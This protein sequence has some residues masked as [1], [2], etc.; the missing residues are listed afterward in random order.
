LEA[1]VFKNFFGKKKMQLIGL[2]I[3]TRYIKAV[4]L[5][6]DKDQIKVQAVACEAINGNAFAERDI[7][8]FEAVSQALRKIKLV[9][10]NK[11]KFVAIAIAGPSV[12][13]KVVYMEPDQSD[14]ELESQIELEAESLI[15]Y[16]LDEVYIDFEELN[17]SET[18][19]NK[20]EVLLS[21]ALKDMID[22]RRTLLGE[23]S[24]EA[25]I[26][27]IETYSL[28]AAIKQFYPK[29]LEQAV[30]CINI[31]A[32]L[33]Q[34]CVVS[35]KQ[36]TYTKEHSFGVDS[37]IQ[38]LG[39]MYTLERAEVEQQLQA[40]TLPENWKQDAYPL[41]LSNLQQ[42]ISRALQTYISARQATR[43][44]EILISGGGSN[45]PNIAKNLAAE[46]AIDVQV[47]NPFAEMKISEQAAKQNIMNYAPQLAIAAGLASR[48]F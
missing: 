34:I 19:S 43:P 36:L 18:H 17:T 37:L 3:G 40:D 44:T 13:S 47:F 8:D 39:M 27:D 5:E 28:E 9:M 15:P 32:T 48:S 2:D 14:F 38:D 29:R 26:V 30:C 42:H 6:K 16:P 41:F 25:H 20:V 4:L 23:V 46:L 1:L 35:N 31:G 10:K 11:H 33:L 24:Y 22:G 12:L 21:A 45:L 7:K